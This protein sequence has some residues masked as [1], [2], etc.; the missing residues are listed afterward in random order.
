MDFIPFFHEHQGRSERKVGKFIREDASKWVL[1]SLS[2]ARNEG[3]MWQSIKESD[4]ALMTH[5]RCHQTEDFNDFSELRV[6]EFT[7][8]MEDVRKNHVS[9]GERTIPYYWLADR[10]PTKMVAY[11]TLS[12]KPN[13]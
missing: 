12:D 2:F 11:V 7:T 13:S 1:A 10:Y 6:E 4:N 5:G 3:K 9:H 8:E